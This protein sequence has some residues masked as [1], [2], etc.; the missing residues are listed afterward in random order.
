MSAEE[1]AG[2]LAPL[3]AALNF[4]SFLCLVAGLVYIKRRDLRRHRS[5]MTAALTAS[6]LFLVFYITRFSLTGT[7]RFAGE[8]LA[9]SAYFFILFSHMVLA[10]IVAPAVAR[11]VYLVRHRRFRS[12][13]ALARWVY[14][15]WLY[16]SITGIMVYLMLYHI[17]GYV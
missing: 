7:H 12:H 13:A 8:G 16:V 14:P 5:A 9:R 10:A 2:V 15:V 4:T 6:V 11:L 1:I 3:N 17:Y